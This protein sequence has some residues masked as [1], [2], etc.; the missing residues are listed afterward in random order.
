VQV[1]K[2]WGLLWP[3]SRHVFGSVQFD[4]VTLRQEQR[5]LGSRR[6]PKLIT[7]Y[8]VRFEGEKRLLV[9]GDLPKDKA[10]AL[11]REI[12]DYLD[13]PLESTLPEETEKDKAQ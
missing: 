6:K 4:K 11:A 9:R 8:P 12:A 1:T 2:W 5:Q 3:W 10:R 13:L 7:E